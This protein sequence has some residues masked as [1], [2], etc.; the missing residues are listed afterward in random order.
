MK[1]CIFL[2][3]L[4]VTN[5]ASN[6]QSYD[7]ELRA[8]YSGRNQNFDDLVG[9][10]ESI[11]KTKFEERSIEYAALKSAARKHFSLTNYEGRIYLGLYVVNDYDENAYPF[12]R[13]FTDK[14]I[15]FESISPLIGSFGQ[16]LDLLKCDILELFDAK[17]SNN[18]LASIA[19]VK[20]LKVLG[21][22][23]RGFGF[24]ENT[25]FPEALEMLIVRNAYLNDHFFAALSK[26]DKLKTLVLV[27]CGI[28][29]ESPVNAGISYT[30]NTW[31][32][33]PRLFKKSSDIIS[34]LKIIDSDPAIFNH[35][36]RKQWVNLKDVHVVLQFDNARAIH[37]ITS[38]KYGEFQD[39]FK[40]F[41]A[42]KSFSFKEHG[43]EHPRL[44]EDFNNVKVTQP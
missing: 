20:S 8:Y 29:Y 16:E 12:V 22:P 13:L 24:D 28:S 19:T 14:D 1:I 27:N 18:N 44:R 33:Y 9:R 2:L 37:Y 11:F 5:S 42:L 41:P 26:L 25:I 21:L 36:V 34:S 17:V 3:I 38:D 10:A 30:S 32:D 31:N 6:S 39:A 23:R 4:F 35:V 43:Y 40:S 15:K 7:G